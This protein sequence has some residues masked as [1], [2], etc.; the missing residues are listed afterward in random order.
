[1]SDVLSPTQVIHLLQ[2]RIG[3]DFSGE[4]HLTEEEA[5]DIIC[6]LSDNVLV[7]REPSKKQISDGIAAWSFDDSEPIT[8]VY[9]I[10]K[11]MID[12]KQT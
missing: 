2:G 10:Y 4:C 9:R 6:M 5:N 7:S 3:Q 12:E 8:A 1:M 11:A